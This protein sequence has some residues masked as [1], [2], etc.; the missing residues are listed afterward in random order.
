MKSNVHEIRHKKECELDIMSS[1]INNIEEDIFQNSESLFLSSVLTINEDGDRKD[2]ILL[3]FPNSL[4]MLAQN[5]NR[6]N[7]FDFDKQINFLNVS[8]NSVVQ[9]KKA[10]SIDSIN[11]SYGGNL[12]D[13]ISL[14][15]C[16]ELICSQTSRYLIICSTSY[17]LKMWL[18]LISHLLSKAQFSLNN[19]SL[20][21]PGNLLNNSQ[22]FKA[23]LLTSPVS[24]KHNTGTSFKQLTGNLSGSA[25]NNSIT[26]S[27]SKAKVFSLR[28]HPPLIPHFQ[29]PNDV[30]LSPSIQ[31]NASSNNNNSDNN[32]TIKRFMY[33]KAKLSEP[34][35]KC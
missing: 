4:V 23:G 10:N 6:P 28:P 22:S 1:R 12:G 33:K 9:I 31:A 2:R 35:G 16:F 27:S 30:T 5:S 7:E 15:Y 19:K 8:T 24:S 21:S 18:E 14:K 3:L 20:K 34:F 26:S 13:V 32:Q 25:L 17:D 29:L 11:H